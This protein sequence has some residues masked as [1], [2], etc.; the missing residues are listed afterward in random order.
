MRDVV[1]RG[2]EVDVP[3]ATGCCMFVRGSTLRTVR[4]F[5]PEFFLY[6]EDYDLSARLS[7]LGAVRYVPSVLITHAGGFTSSR[8]WRRIR[9]FLASAVRYFSLHGWRW[10]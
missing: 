9:L 7:R 3:L 1:G 8:G 10:V 2:V 6:F 4:G 5:S